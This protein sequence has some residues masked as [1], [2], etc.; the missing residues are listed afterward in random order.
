M[1]NSNLL[2]SEIVFGLTVLATFIASILARSH[3]ANK[4]K[5][6]LSDEKLN[7]WLV[8]LS[9]GTTANSGFIVTAAVG[10]GYMYGLHW[11]MLP[12]S[13][14]LGDMLFWYLFPAR[15]N[16]FGIKNRSTT[17][18]DIITSGQ[19][20]ALTKLTTIVCAAVIL[21]CLAGYTSAQ[22]LAGQKFL[23]GAFQLPETT[24]LLL[25]SVIIVAYSAIGGF[26]GSVYT[27][28]LQAFVR[29]AGTLVAI[30]AIAIYSY[31]APAFSQNLAQAGDDFT[32]FFPQKGLVAIFGFIIGFAAASVGFGLGQPQIIS[33]YLAGRDPD[34]T[35]SAWWI[36]ISFVQFTWIAMTLFGVLL[37]GVMPNIPDPE[38]GLS[39]F[40]QTHLG[41]ILTGI[42][43]AD[44][45]ATIAATS[46]GIIIA[47]S[48]TIIYDI[49]RKMLGYDW[50]QKESERYMTVATV[51]IGLSTM[52]ISLV[53]HG[54]VLDLALSS[55]ALMGSGLAAAVIIKVF[56]WRHSSLSIF[57]AIIC[58]LAASI[59][60]KL[61]GFSNY[62]NEAAIGIVIG[63]SANF[64]A[65]LS[66]SGKA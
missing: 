47:M 51:A 57:I 40:F 26:R 50:S 22:W 39:T 16:D 5:D 23:T 54:S 3:T 19:S 1:S 6:G 27:D 17:I 43:V 34:E 41:P 29:I 48:Q 52:L 28:T 63:L 9:A 11:I 10:L 53:L 62:M 31:N 61:F 56:N 38:T 42:I 21:I 4:Q 55:V 46:N 8:G 64:I 33:R 60:W 35:R 25:F 45:F 12:L 59:L 20:G 66:K 49:G 30:I 58:G 36:Y 24:S 44:V 37:R 32:Q 15:I 14:L 18:V 2:F 13:W 7:K 65:C